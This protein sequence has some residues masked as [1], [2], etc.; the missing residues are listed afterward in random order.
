M[1]Y[2]DRSPD[3]HLVAAASAAVAAAAAFH[4]WPEHMRFV[5]AAA[6]AV[7][8]LELVVLQRCQ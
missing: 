4:L 7:A 5:V 8:G 3:S 1:G 6:A 2:L